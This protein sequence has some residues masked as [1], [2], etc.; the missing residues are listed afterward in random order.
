MLF[1]F[2]TLFFFFVLDPRKRRNDS[3]EK[4][5]RGNGVAVNEKENGGNGVAAQLSSTRPSTRPSSPPCLRQ[6]I[7]QLD[8]FP[9]G[10][11]VVLLLF[12]FSSLCP[13]S[14][15][16]VGVFLFLLM[17]VFPLSVSLR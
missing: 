6:P 3:D 9:P 1:L 16:G 2:F 15:G 5:N 12:A 13:F 11:F 8:F 7:S 4:E 14:M 10:L 17:S